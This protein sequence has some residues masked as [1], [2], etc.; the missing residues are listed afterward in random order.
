MTE[1]ILTHGSTILCYLSFVFGQFLFLL[2]R[3]NS[4]K[5]N[6]TSDISTTTDFF[7]ESLIPIIVRGS[8]EL[9]AFVL[10]QRYPAIVGWIINLWGW[11]LPVGVAN[12]LNQPIFFI[13]WLF[14][15]YAADSMLDAASISSKVPELIRNWIKEN[16]PTNKFYRAGAIDPP[17]ST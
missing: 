11:H 3:A 1:W 4:A 8:L 2:K 15:G 6:S 13:F 10:L 12:A 17:Q 7:R 14:A 9:A 5:L 16:V